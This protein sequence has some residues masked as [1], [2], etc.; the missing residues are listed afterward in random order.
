MSSAPSRARRLVW[1]VGILALV[2]FAVSELDERSDDSDTA[3]SAITTMTGRLTVTDLKD[4]DSFEASDGREYRLGMV[5]TPEPDER[6]FDEAEAFTRD[7]LAG[8]F[9]ADAYD[10][11]DYGRVV[12][13]VLDREGRSLNVALAR[14]GLADDRYL[15]PFRGDHPDL[16]DR[17]DDAFATAK[18]PTCR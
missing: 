18:K 15:D 3:A 1:A 4:G 7:F 8:G 6:C 16:A 13:E 5:N 9:T 11:D 10:E 2:W 12:A 17:L 14:S